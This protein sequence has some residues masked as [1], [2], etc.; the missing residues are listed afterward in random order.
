MPKA[1]LK[2]PESASISKSA[3]KPP[4]KKIDSF[5]VNA[6]TA[7]QEFFLAGLQEIYWAENHLLKAIPKMIDAA[8]GANLKKVLTSHLSVTKTHSA[9]LEKAFDTLEQKRLSRK[10]DAM[11]GLTMSGEHVI[12]NTIAGTP[13]RDMGITMSAIKVENFEA[14]TYKGLIQLATNL[15]QGDIA[16]LLRQTLEEELAAGDRLTDMSQSFAPSPKS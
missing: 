1:P 13:V 5:P 10:C 6:H 8:G 16:E 4:S 2:N 9:R 15:G 12:E 11:E 14:V 3:T 7:M